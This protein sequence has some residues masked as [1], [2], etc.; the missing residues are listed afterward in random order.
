MIV[1]QDEHDGL[2]VQGRRL[3]VDAK[4][5]GMTRRRLMLQQ[6]TLKRK[7]EAGVDE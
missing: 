7:N 3:M 6:V 1:G 2:Y 5:I 4:V